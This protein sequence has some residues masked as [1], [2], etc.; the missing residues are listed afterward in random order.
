MAAEKGLVLF[1]DLVRGRPDA[2]D[3]QLVALG[4][5]VPRGGRVVRNRVDDDGG[6][7]VGG[8]VRD[9]LGAV[10]AAHADTA[11]GRSCSTRCFRSARM[12]MRMYSARDR[13]S[14]SA[15]CRMARSSSFI[16]WT[17]IVFPRAPFC[18]LL[19]GS[20]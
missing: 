2:F 12:S 1:R 17:E 10:G 5:A 7:G 19:M 3:L 13:F 16:N 20:R 11:T 8:L 4:R 6:R 14:F 15:A 18:F 9:D